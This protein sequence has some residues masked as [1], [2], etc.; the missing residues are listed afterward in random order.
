[1]RFWAK[2]PSVM[3]RSS[4]SIVR[5]V[6]PET[7][8]WLMRLRYLS[9]F[10]KS[11]KRC[12]GSVVIVSS[13]MFHPSPLGFCFSIRLLFCVGV[14]RVCVL[15][16]LGLLVFGLFVGVSWLTIRFFVGGR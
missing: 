14:G 13:V 8:I 3:D 5:E 12:C 9:C 7:A 1:M 11:W 16:W 6:E 2:S 4:K 10:R 15:L